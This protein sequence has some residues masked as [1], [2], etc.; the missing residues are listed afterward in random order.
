[1]GLA[2][3][4]THGAVRE[5]GAGALG[6]DSRREQRLT[7]YC[8]PTHRASPGQ[9]YFLSWSEDTLATRKMTSLL[10]GNN[11]E[12]NGLPG[13]RAD[14]ATQTWTIASAES[15]QG[16]NVKQH[17][18]ATPPSGKGARA[19]ERNL[20][21]TRIFRG[22]WSIDDVFK[23]NTCDRS[24]QVDEWTSN[25]EEV[26]GD[27]KEPDDTQDA[28]QGDTTSSDPREESSQLMSLGSTWADKGE[29][30]ARPPWASSRHLG[31]SMKPKLSSMS[32]DC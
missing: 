14:K 20:K 23:V 10:K 21:H 19:M 26:K 8:T 1:M 13:G 30:V 9:S 22:N 28:N 24:P 16:P 2:D 11:E 15:L 32:R 17:S 6:K 4:T 18:G 7:P 27:R 31:W 29:P 25:V 3:P 5:K 12:S